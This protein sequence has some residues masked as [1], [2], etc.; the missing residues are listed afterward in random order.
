MFGTLFQFVNVI[1]LHIS[2]D[3]NKTHGMGH[4]LKHNAPAVD[5]FQVFHYFL[6]LQ[7]TSKE[8]NCHERLKSSFLIHSIRHSLN[9]LSK[10]QR[11]YFLIKLAQSVGIL[12]Y[13]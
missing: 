1:E 8:R 3:C 13:I 7:V 10:L 9:I 5:S 2:T 11:L 6:I 12:F 4:F